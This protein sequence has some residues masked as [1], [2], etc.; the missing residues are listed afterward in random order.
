[1][2]DG[3][4]ER[5]QQVQTHVVFGS[6]AGASHESRTAARV[7]WSGIL[8]V[9]VPVVAEQLTDVLDWMRLLRRWV[10][11]RT[12]AWLQSQPP[13]GRRFRGVN[14]ERQCM[15]LYRLSATADQKVSLTYTPQSDK[16]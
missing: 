10:V 8:C 5:C 13:L 7:P 1:M 15:G 6:N 16:A 2:S 9:A 12:L 3:D 11:E 14:R 4:H